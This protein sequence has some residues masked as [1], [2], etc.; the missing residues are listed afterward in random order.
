MW[1]WTTSEILVQRAIFR[2]HVLLVPISKRRENGA[3]G[4]APSH[5]RPV[6]R[7]GQNCH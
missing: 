5:M 7:P 6:K 3:D 1:N 2:V 4:L